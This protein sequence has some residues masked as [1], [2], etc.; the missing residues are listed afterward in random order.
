MLDQLL[1]QF[2]DHLRYERNVSIHTLRNYESDLLQFF[3]REPVGET[4]RA[5]GKGKRD[6]DRPEYYI[7]R[8]LS[9]LSFNW[10][11]LEEAYNPRNP[12]L[13]RIRFLS[14][15]ALNLDEFTMVRFAGLKEQ[16]RHGVETPSMDGMTPTR[17]LE[18]LREHDG[19]AWQQ[20][21]CLV[22]SP[23]G[24]WRWPDRPWLPL[25][26]SLSMRKG[27]PASG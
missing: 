14:I 5:F 13:E 3:A 22:R 26:L 20:Y 17:Q 19:V 18:C 9:W 6:L 27:P 8:E 11:V 15:S 24:C 2:L 16:Q 1:T 4:L 7:N 12:L 25:A 10:R 21:K 23:D